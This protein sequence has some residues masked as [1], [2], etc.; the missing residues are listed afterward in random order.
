MTLFYNTGPELNEV[1]SVFEAVS[2][3]A[4]WGFSGCDAFVNPFARVVTML[5]ICSSAAWACFA[6][7]QPFRRKDSAAA[8]RAVQPQAHIN[9]G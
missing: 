7:H 1:N 4:P 9:V 5:T 2:A 3:S 6:G 8:R